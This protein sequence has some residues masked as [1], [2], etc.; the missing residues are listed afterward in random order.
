RGTANSLLDDKTFVKDHKKSIIDT[1]NQMVGL[2]MGGID[3]RMIDEIDEEVES[4]GK[5]DPSI[6]YESELIKAFQSDQSVFERTNAVRKSNKRTRLRD[7]TRMTDEQLEGWYIMFQRNPRKDKIL[8]KYEFKGNREE[9]SSSASEKEN[10]DSLSHPGRGESYVRDRNGRDNYNG[11]SSQT[12][13][14]PARGRGRGKYQK[15]HNRKNAH[16]RKMG[17]GFG[18]IQD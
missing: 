9:A 12:T 10:G 1:A 15:K 3:L 16:S 17:R 13:T 4:R 6:T 7:L 14:P 18:T 11:E 2:K 5:V 8:E